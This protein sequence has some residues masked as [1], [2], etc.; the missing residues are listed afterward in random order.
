MPSE[1]KIGLRQEE[2]KAPYLKGHMGLNPSY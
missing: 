1:T 2:A